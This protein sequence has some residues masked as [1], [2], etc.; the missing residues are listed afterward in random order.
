MSMGVKPGNEALRTRL[1]GVIDRR[2]AEITRIL[3]DYGVP[4]LE[5]SVSPKP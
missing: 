1:E 3:K 5:R 4:L 2:H